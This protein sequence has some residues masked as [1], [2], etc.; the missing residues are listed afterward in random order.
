MNYF[1]WTE[2]FNCGKIG[3]IA[4][5][6]FIIHH[7]GLI[8]H[9]F[10]FEKDFE[11]IENSSCI[12][13]MILKEKDWLD[14]LSL[15]F[16]RKYEKNFF[17]NRLSHRSIIDGFESGHLGTARLWAHIIKVRKEKILI[18]FD[19]DVIFLDNIINEMLEL[20]KFY[21]L[22]GPIRN[23]KNNPN[24]IQF[25]EQFENL[26]QTY[27]FL[28][29]RDKIGK[30]SYKELVDLC[31]GRYK[32][33]AVLDFFDPIMFTILE[34]KGK[35]YFLNQDDV[36]G[37][38]YEGKRDNK[39]KEINNYDTPFKLDFGNKLVHFS[40][41]GSGMNIYNNKNTNIQEFYMRYA[42]DRY[43]LFCKIF[44]DETID[45]DLTKYDKLILYFK[46][47]IVSKFIN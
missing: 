29:N 2:I 41:V 11:F 4:L 45:I 22:V 19:S 3:R 7:P 8:V 14:D 30:F 17:E 10:G 27:C 33:H 31:I 9:V 16:S 34:N 5:K 32:K 46:D 38:D 35:I 42:L 44:Y 15:M 20:G 28:F 21:D 37:C 26:S 25:F 36:G 13:P 43:A 6:S 18:H 23:Y 12:I 1:I 39:F 47:N 24:K 40:A